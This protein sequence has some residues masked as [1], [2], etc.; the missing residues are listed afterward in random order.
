MYRFKI[1]SNS[2]IFRIY[3]LLISILMAFILSP[4]IIFIYILCFIE[5][6]KPIFVQVRVGK[7]LRPFHLY[8][9]RTMLINTP[10]LSSHLINSKSV[11]KIGKFIR[12]LKIDELPQL[13]NVIKGEMSLIGPRPCL[14]NQEKLV[15]ERKKNN[16]FSVK[17]GITGLAQIK[18]IDM[19]MPENLAK[20]DAF[21]ISNLNHK[22]YF[23]YLLLTLYGKGFGDK[24]KK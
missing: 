17:P 2:K 7:D 9:F 10:S 21:M 3:D 14:Y 23:K 24:T 13:F 11:T 22:N 4:L 18:G 12:L 6:G 19:S 1:L 8:K 15:K 5:S 16:V 20:I